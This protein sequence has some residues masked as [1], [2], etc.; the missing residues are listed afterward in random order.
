MINIILFTKVHIEIIKIIKF[1][2]L[3]YYIDLSERILTAAKLQLDTAELRKELYFIRIN[4]LYD[5][6]N[7]DELKKMF[8]I[9]IYNYYVF[10]IENEK[11]QTKKPYTLK[12][13]KFSKYMLS[14]NDIEYGILRIQRY[15]IGFYKICNL[16]YPS[17]VKKLSLEEKD[18]KIIL[19]LNKIL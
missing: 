19:Q 18:S 10:I 15:N 11:L 6:L 5:K 14:L 16:F 3:N 2:T 12:R 1:T 8:W 4:T 17:Y 13:I 9:N 7:T